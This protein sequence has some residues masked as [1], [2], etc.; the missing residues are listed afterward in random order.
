MPFIIS[1]LEFQNDQ[2]AAKKR[3]R[4]HPPPKY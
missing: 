3:R 2:F 1:G 4:N